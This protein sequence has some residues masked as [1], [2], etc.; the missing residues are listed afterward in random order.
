MR[1]RISAAAN[2]LSVKLW[3]IVPP[4]VIKEAY[5]D[6]F[7]KRVRAVTMYLDG[8][9]GKDIQLATGISAKTIALYVDRCLKLGDDGRIL[10]FRALIPYLHLKPYT[11]TSGPSPKQPEQQGGQSGEMS[12]LLTRLPDLNDILTANILQS[13]KAKK[14]PEARLRGRDLHNIFI[15]AIKELGVTGDEW[16]FNSKY[17]GLR[18]ITTYMRAI[19]YRN[20]SRSVAAWGSDEAKAHLPTGT[21]KK[22]LFNF[23]EPYDAVEIDAYRIDA[24]LTIAMQTPEGAETE[25]LLDRLWLIAAVDVAST[26]IL[27]YQIVYSSVV[28]AADV[29]RV[30]R[31]ASTTKWKPMELTVPGLNYREGSGFPSGIIP[32]AENALWSVTMLDGALSNLAMAVH[33]GCRKT[34]GFSLNYGSPGHFEKRPNV[35]NTFGQIADN[36]FHRLPSTT[37]SNPHNGR[38]ANAEQK[39]IRHKIRA[40]ETLQLVDVA[41]ALHNLTPCK[42]LSSLSRLAFISYFLSGPRPRVEARK[43]PLDMIHKARKI[44]LTQEATIRGSL[45]NGRRPYVERDGGIYTNDVIGSTSALIN[46]KIIITIEEDDYRQ[47]EAFM[48][49]GAPL[50]FL[51]VGGKW[52]DIKHSVATRKKI[53]SLVHRRILFLSEFECP[54]TTYLRY[55]ATSSAGKQKSAPRVS[56]KNATEIMRVTQESDEEVPV[57]SPAI[58]P[59]NRILKQFEAE[60]APRRTTMPSV[61]GLFDKVRNRR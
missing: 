26:A 15:T 13:A 21:G 58:S 31:D 39:A 22:A 41:L 54:V 50:G 36:I 16:P 46:Q 43:L 32:E 38:A 45:E 7:N 52:S 33:D 37:G 30:I 14:I 53:N 25:I 59:R 23:P 18:S 40:Q 19:L 60:V 34:F 3:P 12:R 6:K 61:I 29:I 17:R 44:L 55:L 8:Y 48:P 2:A 27:A 24:F 57:V 49:D 9:P 47:F 35:E 28:R 42:G 56:K 20:F 10:G 4:E 51:L 11:R 5:R 1:K